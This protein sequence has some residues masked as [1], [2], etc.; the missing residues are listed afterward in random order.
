MLRGLRAVVPLAARRSL[1]RIASSIMSTAKGDDAA[2]SFAVQ[3]NVTELRQILKTIDTNVAKAK[4]AKALDLG[5]ESVAMPN[6]D[7]LN[8]MVEFKAEGNTR[9]LQLKLKWKLDTG[10]S[11]APTNSMPRIEEVAHDLFLKLALQKA[12][13]RW[14]CQISVC[15]TI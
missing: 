1:P 13:L 11:S 10:G 5:K 6:R 4:P 7:D 2:Q 8:I 12:G 3:R 9:E 14:A 15:C